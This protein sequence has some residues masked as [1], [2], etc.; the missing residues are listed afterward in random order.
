MALFTGLQG[1][2]VSGKRIKIDAVDV[3]PGMFVA[4]LDRPWLETPF[5]FQGFELREDS[6]IDQLRH[7]CKHVFVDLK[8]SSMSE[9]EFEKHRRKPDDIALAAFDT[10]NKTH[11]PKPA[12]FMRWLAK[13]FAGLDPTGTITRKLDGVYIYR[14]KVSTRREAPRAAASYAGAVEIM[15]GVL[16]QVR[17]GGAV[18]VDNVR[19]AVTPMIDSVLRNPDAMSW[20]VTLQKRDDYSYH[21]SI[22]TSVWAVVLGRHLGLDRYSLDTLAIG[23]MLLD[24]GKT[25]LPEELLKKPARLSAHEADLMCQH[26]DFSLDIVRSSSAVSREILDMIESHHERYDGSGYPR[27]LSGAEIPVYGRIA[28]IVDC[29]DAMVTSRPY[30]PAR[31]SYDAVRELNKLSGTLFQKEL[32]EQFVQALGMFPTGSLVEL[33]TGEVG[34]VV[35]Q[36]R[37]RRLRPKVMLLLDDCKQPITKHRT[38]DLRKL[39]S[40]TRSPK[41]V[42]IQHGLESGAY[43]INPQDYFM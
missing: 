4:Q 3:A 31:S 1:L 2:F 22:A 7:Y 28:G 35:E 39:S 36:N 6:E 26:V 37:V 20:F 17:D 15:N 18:D 30:Q 27:G 42:W 33:S 32:V 29:Y 41:A 19:G 14:N 34:V 10:H 9:T 43:D 5:L 8:R 12:G 13:K 16:A 25:R 38:V 11:T 23:G 40:D 21:H 24:I